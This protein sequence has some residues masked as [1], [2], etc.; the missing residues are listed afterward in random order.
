M[1]FGAVKLHKNLITQWFS[2]IASRQ[3]VILPV[4]GEDIIRR[5]GI[6]LN[7]KGIQTAANPREANVL[8][9]PG[10]LPGQLYESAAILYAQMPRPRLIAKLGEGNIH[11]LPK[12]DLMITA[13]QS[14]EQIIPEIRRLLKENYKKDPQS[15]EPDFI[16]GIL[17]KR[18]EQQQQG[19]HQHHHHGNEDND[20]SSH[21]GHE[22]HK[23]EHEGHK[24][25]E[26]HEN[27]HHEND[28]KNGEH[29]HHE[30]HGQKRHG[31]Q[32]HHQEEHENEHEHKN[33]EENQH[34]GHQ[35]H[36]SGGGHGGHQHGMG[37]MSMVMMTKDMPRSLDGLAMERNE[38]YF[39]PFFPGLPAG[40][41]IKMHLDGDT[42]IK[43]EVEKQIIANHWKEVCPSSKRSFPE[44]WL[45][46]PKTNNAP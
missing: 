42:V 11:P 12:P 18:S 25:H 7:Q 1:S 8:L 34:Q 17:K 2:N 15:Y 27:Q 19:G 30:E 3:V 37:F 10:S 40:L 43:A 9:I 13:N 16:N 33:H 24:D 4:P 35:H 14:L 20:H 21:E 41:I 38:V 29:E 6:V 44:K 26:H 46:L 45:C 32:D 36:D 5:Y 39:G 28:H 23:K 22:H 31:H